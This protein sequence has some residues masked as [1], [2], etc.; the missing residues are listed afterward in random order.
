MSHPLNRETAMADHFIVMGDILKSSKYD[1]RELM[2]DFKR[3]VLSCNK[4]LADGILSPYTVTLGD[5]FQGVSKSLHWSVQSLLYLEE[6]SLQKGFPFALRYV[7]HYGRIDTPLNRKIAHGM[8][9]RGLTHAR[10]LLTTK[11]R[12]LPRFLFDLPNQNLATQL[13]QLFGV[14]ASITRD[15]KRRDADLIFD[16]LSSDDNTAIGAK[17][18]KNRSQIWKRRRNMHVDDYK[19]LRAI[20]IQLSQGEGTE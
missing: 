14:M 18:G 1:G 10:E 4:K 17:H 5:E 19:A 6:S 13:S 20:A 3:L 15:W 2:R 7:V 9:G 12:G 11:H 8:V 16:M